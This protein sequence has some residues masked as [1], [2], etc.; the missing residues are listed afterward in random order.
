MGTKLF[1]VYPVVRSPRSTLAPAHTSRCR[2]CARV[3]PSRPRRG[4]HARPPTQSIALGNDPHELPAPPAPTLRCSKW[5]TNTRRALLSFADVP[6]TAL[7]ASL[8]ARARSPAARSCAARSRRSRPGPAATKPAT[9]PTQVRAASRE[10]PAPSIE[11]SIAPYEDDNRSLR[12]EE[13]RR[14]TRASSVSS[15]RSR[16]TRPRVARARLFDRRT[17]FQP[18]FVSHAT[19]RIFRLLSSSRPRFH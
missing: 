13:T 17:V 18:S 10:N 15:P 9:P 2:C 16:E 4:T 12:R 3:W 7:R 14:E 8:A 5:V 11:D 1:D 19:R 6:V